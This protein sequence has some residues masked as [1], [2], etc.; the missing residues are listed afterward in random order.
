MDMRPLGR[1][2]ITVSRLC[3]GTMMFGGPTDAATS[4]RILDRAAE[5]G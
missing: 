1:S 5:A 2:G 3:V 4:Q